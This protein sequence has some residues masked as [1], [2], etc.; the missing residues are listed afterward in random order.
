MNEGEAKRYAESINAIFELI[1]S[2]WGSKIEEL[3][4]DIGIKFLEKHGYIKRE[5]QEKLSFLDK[6]NKFYSF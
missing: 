1:S 2:K 5:I 4:E 6:L 3:F